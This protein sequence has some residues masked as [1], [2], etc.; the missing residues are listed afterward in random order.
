MELTIDW[1][2][3]F[4]IFSIA[5]SSAFYYFI[6]SIG[7]PPPSIPPSISGE[8]FPS[9]QLEIRK[10]SPHAYLI[11]SGERQVYVRVII[12]SPR[13][14]ALVLKGATPLIL[15]RAGFIVAFSGSAVAYAGTPPRDVTF[16]ISR[17]GVFTR[18]MEIP[19]V[20]I[21]NG[22]VSVHPSASLGEFRVPQYGLPILINGT[23]F[24]V[25]SRE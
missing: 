11:T 20:K 18:P 10:I 22:V 4:M 3:G 1:L 23:L 7:Y 2:V 12:L 16:Y 15:P 6:A 13:G 17:H 14:E 5:V 21:S 25:I 24:R 8:L 9:T 19:Y